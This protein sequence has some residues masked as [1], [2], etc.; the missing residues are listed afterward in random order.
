MH[1]LGNPGILT[2]LSYLPRKVVIVGQTRVG[3][4]LCTTPALRAFGHALPNTEMV[5][6]APSALRDLA[7]R[8]PHLNRFVAMPDLLF[9]QESRPIDARGFTEFL[10]AMQAERFDLGIQLRGYGLRSSPYFVLLG[11]A[12]NVGFMGPADMPLLDAAMPFP[13]EGHLIDRFLKLV[14]F[15]GVP[16]SGRHMEFGLDPEDHAAA[17]S[18]LAGA[19]SPLIGIHPGA[20]EQERMW[21]PERFASVAC[22]WKNITPCPWGNH[23]EAVCLRCK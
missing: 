23:Q 16:S 20:T 13:K 11:A 19:G 22:D 6:I 7:A 14:A 9:E 4:F 1:T 2:R 12:L 8:S 10:R 18:L 21:Q 3:G 17:T 15:L 5:M